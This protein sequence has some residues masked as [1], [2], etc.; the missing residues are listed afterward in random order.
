MF[1]FAICVALACLPLWLSGCSATQA[2]AEHEH[3]HAHGSPPTFEGLVKRVRKQHHW[4]AQA[5]SREDVKHFQRELRHFTESVGLLP[6]LAAET[7]LNRADWDRANAAAK[8]LIAESVRLGQTKTPLADSERK[9]VDGA[10]QTLDELA[11]K[12]PAQRSDTNE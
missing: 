7:D 11:A 12:L 5:A 9:S 1:R 10:F 4:A 6:E 3:H 2:E 8:V